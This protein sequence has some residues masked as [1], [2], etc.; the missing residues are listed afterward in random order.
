MITIDE[1]TKISDILDSNEKAIEAIAMINSNFNKLK[2]PILRKFLAKRVD[3]KQAASIGGVHPNI[4][5]GELSKIGFIVQYPEIPLQ[6]KE[7]FKTKYS[8]MSKLRTV[9]LDVRPI[10]DSGVDPFKEIMAKLK[11]MNDDEELLIINT[12]EPIPLLNILKDK[13]Y[14]YETIRP[15]EGEVHTRL[16][17]VNTNIDITPI[18]ISNKKE[19]TFEAAQEEF[20]GNMYEADVRDLEM[21]MPMVTILEEVEK[22]GE[23]QALFVHHNKLPQ[24][25]I[26]ELENRGFSFVTNEIDDQN[27]K[28]IIFKS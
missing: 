6:N 8:Q 5:L 28:L 18:N 21:P 1:N 24:Y 22:I 13:G 12:F 23:G 14:Q 4:L 9:I 25:L 11:E 2:N 17:K 3:I 10:L 26:P 20:Q 7:K 15:K 27:I 19:R 16:F